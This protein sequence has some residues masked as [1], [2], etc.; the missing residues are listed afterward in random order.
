MFDA[1]PGRTKLAPR[2][3]C[4]FGFLGSSVFGLSSATQ[5]KSHEKK[6]DYVIF[7]G[8]F[9][10]HHPEKLGFKQ[11]CRSPAAATAFCLFRPYMMWFVVLLY[12]GRVTKTV[13]TGSRA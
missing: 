3:S 7:T 13:D 10:R 8:D 12:Q 5:E 6:S 9:T 2:V 11:P 1:G 4:V